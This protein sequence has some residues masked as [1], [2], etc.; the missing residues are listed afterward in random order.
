MPTRVQ[1]VEEP[2]GGFD[3]LFVKLRKHQ[4]IGLQLGNHCVYLSFLN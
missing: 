2:A 3:E 4:Y 1:N